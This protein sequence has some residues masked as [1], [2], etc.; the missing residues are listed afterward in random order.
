M[1]IAM[2]QHLSTPADSVRDVSSST[3]HSP[4][5]SHNGP[6]VIVGAGG[7]GREV[8]DIIEAMNAAGTQLEFAGFIDDGEV[9]S[10]LLERRGAILIGSTQTLSQLDLAYVIGIGNGKVRESIDGFL[11]NSGCLAARLVHPAATVGGDVR[12][13]EGVILAAGSRVTT[14]IALGRHVHLH[15]NSTVGH[16]SVLQDFSSVYPGAT[17]SGNVVLGKG[18]TVGTGANVLPGVTVGHG[19]FVGAGAVV[20]KDVRPNVTVVGSPARE[21]TQRQD[22]L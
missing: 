17:V 20:T 4:M 6:V 22:G 14:N 18:V 10:D 2:T 3:G 7:F 13:S 19:A 8:L 9:R 21:L 15:V 1:L 11:S 12:L 5:M 16:D